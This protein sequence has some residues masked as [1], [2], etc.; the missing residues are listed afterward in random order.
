ML[1]FTNNYPEPVSVMIEFYSPNCSDEG[2]WLGDWVKQ[3]WWNMQPGESKIPFGGDLEDVNRY[4]YFYAH[5]T[6]GAYWAGPVHVDVP[7]FAFDECKYLGQTGT[8]TVGM[9]EID[10]DDN[11]DFTVTLVP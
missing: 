1:R 7:G 3:G 6:D 2:T 5:A 11:D 10:I 8:R 9:R 4:W